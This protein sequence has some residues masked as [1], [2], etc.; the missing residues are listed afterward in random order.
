MTTK[1]P[2]KPRPALDRHRGRPRHETTD[3]TRRERD[4]ERAAARWLYA[5][6]YDALRPTGE[7]FAA[8]LTPPPSFDPAQSAASRL[9]LDA[10]R[11]PT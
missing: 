9:A 7:L 3:P 11:A 2:T 8:R 5:W 1:R 10:A 6:S 4:H